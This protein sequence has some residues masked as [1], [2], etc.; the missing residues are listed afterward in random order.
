MHRCK[1]ME[2]SVRRSPPVKACDPNVS[3]AVV[4]P[5][6]T[7]Q[8]ARKSKHGIV[9]FKECGLYSP[10][11]IAN[12]SENAAADSSSGPR[13]PTTRIEDVWMEFCNA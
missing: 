1:W 7:H 5:S 11:T 8:P 12:I 4:P 13:R 10:V 9:L 2:T 3:S 6:A